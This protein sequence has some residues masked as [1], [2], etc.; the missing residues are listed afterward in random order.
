MGYT[1]KYAFVTDVRYARPI[2]FYSSIGDAIISKNNRISH[3]PSV[4]QSNDTNTCITANKDIIDTA[5]VAVSGTLAYKYVVA[6]GGIAS[7]STLASEEIVVAGGIRATSTLTKERI[8]AAGGV[9][10]PST[11]TNERIVA[12]G[13]V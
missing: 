5:N 4:T 3:W 12:A 1:T 6:A 13:D 9:T 11:I 8:V 7:T 2:N 10:T